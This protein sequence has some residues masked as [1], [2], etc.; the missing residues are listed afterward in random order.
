MFFNP[1]TVIFSIFFI[2]ILVL[3]YFI[4]RL[5]FYYSRV[6]RGTKKE[7]LVEILDTV[8]ADQKKTGKI[9]GEIYKRC[10]TLENEGLLHIQKVGLLRFNPFD[11][12]GGDQSF[13]LAMLDA[14]NSGIV[15]SSLHTRTGTRWYAKKVL[16]GKGT[17]HEL[18]DD[19][20]KTITESKLLAKIN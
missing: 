6:T 2:W 15:I 14:Q 10:D 20:R 18:S 12:T 4:F 9:L 7:S 11:D 1:Q 5:Y 17:E 3:T 16:K 19:E 13:I 8:L